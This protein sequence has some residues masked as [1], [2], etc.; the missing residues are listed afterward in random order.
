M[1][2]QDLSPGKFSRNYGVYLGMF[3][4]II[5]VM[6]YVTGMQI[7]GKQWPMYLFYILFPVVIFY[8]INKYKAHN[9]NLLSLSEALKVGLSIAIVSALVF[10]VY[11]IIFNYIVDPE[12]IQQVANA[13]IERQ[14]E[15]GKITEEMVE[16]SASIREIFTNPII[17]SAVWIALSALFGLIYSLIAGLVMK[18][19][20]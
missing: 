5:A 4:I 18:K 15:S 7:Q 16:K 14:L 20:A 2:T 9:S 8:A 12:F 11:S 17:G 1:E 6:M 3:L 19:E 10:S 13:E